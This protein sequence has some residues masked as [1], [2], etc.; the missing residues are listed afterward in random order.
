MGVTIGNTDLLT[1]ELKDDFKNSSLTHILVVSGA[2]IAFVM[3]IIG[4]FT[5]YLPIHRYAQYSLISGFVIAYGSLVGWDTP[6]LR[7]S[8]MGVISYISIRGNNRIN[9]L[10]ILFLVAMIFLIIEPL[11]LLY[12]ASFGLS[13]GATFGIIVFNPI[14]ENFLKKFLKYNI[15]VTSVSVTLAATL[16][17]A[18]ALIYHFGT[19]GFF[20]I[21][22]N[23]L[24]GGIMGILLILST[25][26][27]FWA[28]IF[29]D[30]FLYFFGL[31]IYFLTEYILMISVFF[32]QF[33]PTQIPENI[34]IPLSTFLY[35]IGFLYAIHA[36]E[37]K[38]ITFQKNH[39]HQSSHH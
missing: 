37:E 29:G 3:L 33:P 26:Y 14:L 28:L 30:I 34:K 11:S 12:D 17:S 15:L 27:I 5:K 6:V 13:F 9:S 22:A 8:I 4:F 1:D 21:F 24:I 23:I 31:P 35:F 32:S 39:S 38:R 2:N 19:F 10:A 7:A 20:G 18:G 16:G 25:F 36:D